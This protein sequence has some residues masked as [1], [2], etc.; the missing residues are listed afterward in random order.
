MFFETLAE[1]WSSTAPNRMSLEHIVLQ[2][3]TSLLRQNGTAQD[4]YGSE[5]ITDII[6]PRIIRNRN[7][8]TITHKVSET[9][10]SFHVK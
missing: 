3:V 1:F 10:S 5:E 8:A 4:N 7:I 9:N 2:F 6:F